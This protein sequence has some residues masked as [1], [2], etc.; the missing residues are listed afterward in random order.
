MV[1]DDIPSSK[2]L[3]PCQFI[4]FYLR[5]HA[6]HAKKRSEIPKLL[7]VQ[8]QARSRNYSR[9][10]SSHLAGRL[11]YTFQEISPAFL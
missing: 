5:V 7:R 4:L 6:F 11:N 1:S 10:N 2:R 8:E 3:R 9:D